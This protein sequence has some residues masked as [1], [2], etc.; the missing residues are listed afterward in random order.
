MVYGAV[1]VAFGFTKPAIFLNAVILAQFSRL[2]QVV[3]VVFEYDKEPEYDW[4]VRIFC[5][6]STVEAVMAI[7]HRPLVDSGDQVA[8]KGES[9]PMAYMKAYGSVAIGQILK[10]LV[11]N[12]NPPIRPW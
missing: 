6:T 5:Y 10:Y 3:A 2:L 7:A 4:L 8:E 11:T 1:S 12:R 9:L